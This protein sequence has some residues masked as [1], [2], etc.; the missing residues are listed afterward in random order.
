MTQPRYFISSDPHLLDL[1][2]IHQFLATESYWA[3]GVSKQVVEKSI[4]HSIPF[5]VYTSPDSTQVGFARVTTDRATFAYLQDL[6]ILSGHR[7]QGLSKRLVETVLGHP[8]LQGLRRFLLATADAHSLY[9]KFGF[10]L[11]P[12]PERFMERRA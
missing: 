12:K 8:D 1:D 2:L 10:E 9:E 7:G 6:F 5:G 3:K 11:L 4:N